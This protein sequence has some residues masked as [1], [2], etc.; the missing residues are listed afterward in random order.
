MAQYQLI[1]IIKQ[2]LSVCCLLAAV[3]LLA[4]TVQAQP[5]QDPD[6]GGALSSSYNYRLLTEAPVYQC[7]IT[8]QGDDLASGTFQIA[9]QDAIFRIIN[10]FGDGYYIVRFWKA[11]TG[12]DPKEYYLISKQEFD[13]KCVV[14]YSTVPTVTAGVVIIPVKL[15]F[16]PFDFSKDITL[17]P[18]LGFRGRIGHYRDNFWNVLGS[19][20]ITSVSVDS[21]TTGGKVRTSSDRSAFTWSVGVVLEALNGAQIGVFL[22]K[23]LLSKNRDEIGWRYNNRTWVSVGLGYSLLNRQSKPISRGE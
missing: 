20:G 16:T 10:K 21:T 22:G 14:R 13:L 11:V 23:D 6:N 9:P 15:R 5:G 18:S 7:D 8:G 17:G 1:A 3:M 12:L 4:T 19:V 2:L